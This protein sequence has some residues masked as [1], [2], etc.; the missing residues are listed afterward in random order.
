MFR[1]SIRELMLLTLVVASL[2]GCKSRSAVAPQPTA[3]PAAKAAAAPQQITKER[4]VEIV[5]ELLA[6][7][8][9]DAVFDCEASELGDEFS[10]FVTFGSKRDADGR[11]ADT[12]PGGHCVYRLSKDGKVTR[13]IGGA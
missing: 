4:A 3:L 2:V 13:I 7:E 5:R 1:F 12:F 10:V 6:K 11:L 8:S 9:P